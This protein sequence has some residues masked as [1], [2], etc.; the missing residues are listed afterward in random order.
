M[1][2]YWESG[3]YWLADEDRETCERGTDGCCVDH[4]RSPEKEECESW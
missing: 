1:S 4:T 3:G 2:V